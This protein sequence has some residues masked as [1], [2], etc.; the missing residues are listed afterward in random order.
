M[1]RVRRTV[2]HPENPGNDLSAP[3]R[4]SRPDAA[5]V[6]R[7]LLMLAR[8]VLYFVARRQSNDGHLTTPAP[9]TVPTRTDGPHA[10]TFIVG[11]ASAVT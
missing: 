11:A 8:P 1:R 10:D 3:I 2:L 5:P 7:L 9:A 4:D 6:D